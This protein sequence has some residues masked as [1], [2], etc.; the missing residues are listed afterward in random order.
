MMVEVERPRRMEAPPRF[1]LGHASR[2]GLTLRM[3]LLVAAHV[4][5]FLAS[6]MVDEFVEWLALELNLLP[7]Q[8]V[9][10]EVTLGLLLFLLWTACML[11]WVRRDDAKQD[12]RRG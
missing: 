12:D 10:L 4:L 11:G 5:V 3:K 1:S 6:Q 8:A 7:A 2:L 9:V